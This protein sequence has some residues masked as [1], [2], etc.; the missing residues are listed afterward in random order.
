MCT[1][2]YISSLA[3]FCIFFLLELLLVCKIEKAH[4]YMVKNLIYCRNIY[5][6]ILGASILLLILLPLTSEIQGF[7]FLWLSCLIW[8]MR[9]KVPSWPRDCD[10]NAVGQILMPSILYFKKIR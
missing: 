9:M 5:L 3:S 2:V 7:T 1:H 10:S 8:E 6:S 4:I